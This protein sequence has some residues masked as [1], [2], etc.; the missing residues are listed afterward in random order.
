MG[1]YDKHLT[2]NGALEIGKTYRVTDFSV[3][4]TTGRFG[5]QASAIVEVEGGIV[6]YI[7]HGAAAVLLDNQ[8]Q[9]RKDMEGG[10]LYVT[11]TTVHSRKYN[12]DYNACDFSYR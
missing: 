4:K 5:D 3:R 6:S 10:H 11:M 9:A 7:P 1:L 2:P 8:E 12:K